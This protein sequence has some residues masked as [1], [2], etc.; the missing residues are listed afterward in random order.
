MS[1]TFDS[2]ANLQNLVKRHY[3]KQNGGDHGYTCLP[4]SEYFTSWIKR[5]V[6]INNIRDAAFLKIMLQNRG[7][8]D[9]LCLDIIIDVIRQNID[10][11]KSLESYNIL[12]KKNL[13]LF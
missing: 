9:R 6:L 3:L 12:T 1:R 2:L 11:C 8:T 4:M 10:S 7:K 5:D 13:V